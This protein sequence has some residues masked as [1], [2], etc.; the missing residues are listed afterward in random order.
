MAVN[1]LQ[2]NNQGQ[3]IL[4]IAFGYLPVTGHLCWSKVSGSSPNHQITAFNALGEGEWNACKGAFFTG[5]EI[6]PSDY[7]FHPGALATGMTTGPQQVGTYFPLDT[8]HSRTA[9]IG[10]KVPVGLGSADIQT[11]PP[12]GF[13][14][15]FETKKCP[16][17]NHLGVQTDFSYTTNPARQIV[18]LLYTYARIPN[19]P[20][21][22]ASSAEY[23]LSRIDWGNWKEFRDF[24]EETETVDYTTIPDFKGFGLTAKFYNGTNFQTFITKFVRPTI[25]F[26]S[27]SS[28]PATGVTASSF[29]AQFDGFIKAPATE[30]RTFHFTHDNG[31]RF[32]IAPAAGSFGTPLIDSWLDNGSSTAGTH[33]GSYAMT[34][35]EFYKVRIQWNNVGLTSQLKFEWSSASQSQQVVPSQYLY[36]EVETRKKYES[37]IWI[38]TPLTVGEGIRRILN[39]TNSIM[40]EPNGK[41]RFFCLDQLTSSFTLDNSN[42]DSF[43]FRRKDILQ[44]DPITEL[45][46]NFRDIDHQFLNEPT[47]AIS[48][49]LDVFT[50]QTAENVL[51]VDL[52][53][54]TRWQARK[55]LAAKAKFEYENRL[56]AD[57]ISPMSKSYPIIAG[58]L[59]TV[60]HRKLG[61]TPKEFLVRKSIDK[62]VA[63]G[64]GQGKDIEKRMFVVQ[65]WE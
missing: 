55:L 54:T 18:E 1:H 44:S 39:Q 61:P 38:D 63:E 4:T 34:A 6:S 32:W 49:K 23:W 20:S 60:Q 12:V 41:L 56:L 17:F 29:S 62:G 5:E 27:T 52:F 9:T 11:T 14:G 51:I 24:H 33:T 58:D 45:E 2:N 28:A 59:I 40:Q 25:D 8:P 64:R 46:A 47:T 65:E 48:H 57:I 13:E 31:V 43:K 26:P 30:S 37:H 16:D 10:Y 22:Y 36:P 50:R 35:G 7:E 42:I 15:L 53:A 21:I 19:L 3:K